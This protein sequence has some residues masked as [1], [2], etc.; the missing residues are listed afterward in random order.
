MGFDPSMGAPLGTGQT[1]L[2]PVTGAPLGS[3][4]IPMERVEFGQSS[5]VRYEDLMKHSQ[6]MAKIPSP[7][8][9]SSYPP[10]SDSSTYRKYAPDYPSTQY[11]PNPTPYNPNSTSYNPN[12]TPYNPNPIREEI[13]STYRKYEKPEELFSPPV[14]QQYSLPFS[15]S[16]KKNGFMG[17]TKS[18]YPIRDAFQNN[19]IDSNS[20]AVGILP[21]NRKVRFSEG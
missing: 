12:P 5:R 8:S 18:S 6:P 10:S 13:D 15:S 14:N 11:N 21:M 20:P 1:G 16:S 9:N 7:Y 3:T 17:S 4:Q 19:S 2:D